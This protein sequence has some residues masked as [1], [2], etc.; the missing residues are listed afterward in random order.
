M[1]DILRIAKTK[2]VIDKAVKE[3]QTRL[4]FYENYFD[5]SILSK[6]LP[7]KVEFC[8]NLVELHFNKVRFIGDSKNFYSGLS[9]IEKSNLFPSLKSVWII[10]S[11]LSYY[12]TELLEGIET[13]DVLCIDDCHIP[14][15]GLL[16]EIAWNHSALR[17]LSI[18]NGGV[19]SLPN[20]FRLLSK[21]EHLDLSYNK[22]ITVPENFSKLS[23]LKEL[24]L[25]ANKMQYLPEELNQMAS[26]EKIDL[27]YNELTEFPEFVFML[28]NLYSIK[29]SDNKIKSIPDRS[30]IPGT[31]TRE[32][33]IRNN[34]IETIPKEIFKRINKLGFDGF[35]VDEP[36]KFY[37]EQRM[38]TYSLYISGNPIVSPDKVLLG[39]G[40]NAIDRFF[41]SQKN[42]EIIN[43]VLPSNPKNVYISY[44]NADVHYKEEL[45]IWLKPL[46]RSQR[47]KLWDD[48]EIAPGLIYEKEI[49]E[50][51]ANSSIIILL[52]SP[53]YI[54][55]DYHYE[56]QLQIALEQQKNN[57]TIVLPILI[58]PCA[59]QMTALASAKILPDNNFPIELFEKK[60]EA[61]QEIFDAI[62]QLV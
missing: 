39:S 61:W 10:G 18:R 29:L 25:R 21:L 3:K 20:S 58:R 62:C 30:F 60:S 16:D 1:L 27:S 12:P 44:S 22:L 40:M 50:Q 51:I 8:K 43:R 24:D 54:G 6:Y 47:I 53:D 28:P 45:Q 49:S 17:V 14:T 11:T 59:Y 23:A 41:N 31:W 15:H 9:P 36:Y 19:T 13:L 56:N 7:S 55:S 32:V 35:A 33:E 57:N 2:S 37:D 4:S 34:Q 5:I 26:L 48:S 38:G 46:E 52:L 42:G